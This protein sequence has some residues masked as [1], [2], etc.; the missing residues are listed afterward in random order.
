[1]GGFNYKPMGTLGW[2]LCQG[3]FGAWFLQFQS[4]CTSLRGN[5]YQRTL[6]INGADATLCKQWLRSF[7]FPQD[8][9]LRLTKIA[10]NPLRPCFFH[11]GNFQV[12]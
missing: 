4:L 9:R 11:V 2:F 7:G 8:L 1:M 12:G 10:G 3:G 6:L 5:A